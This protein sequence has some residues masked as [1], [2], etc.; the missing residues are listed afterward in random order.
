MLKAS[1]DREWTTPKSDFEIELLV[2][3]CIPVV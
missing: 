1:A 3:M 2:T